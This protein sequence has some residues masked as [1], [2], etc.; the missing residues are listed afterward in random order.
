MSPLLA[1]PLVATT[2]VD[3][4]K[5]ARSARG[6]SFCPSTRLAAFSRFISKDLRLPASLPLLLLLLIHSIQKHPKHH[7]LDLVTHLDC[8]IPHT[9]GKHLLPHRR[10]LL[11]C[12]TVQPLH[13]THTF[14]SDSTIPLRNCHHVCQGYYNNPQYPQ[15]AYVAT[16]YLTSAVFHYIPHRI[17]LP[18]AR[19]H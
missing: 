18:S 6:W 16:S 1:D 8:P 10:P 3:L 14:T 7:L 17:S 4:L 5:D 19:Q 11:S 9:S 2:C 13:T 12:Q 15:Q